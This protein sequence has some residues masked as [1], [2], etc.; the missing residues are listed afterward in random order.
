MVAD[1]T[2]PPEVAPEPEL[3]LVG[4]EDSY[5]IHGQMEK[6]I[7]I[8]VVILKM[9]GNICLKKEGLQRTA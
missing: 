9:A 1:Y 8:R 6:I 3:G 7:E 5:P 4:S 2:I